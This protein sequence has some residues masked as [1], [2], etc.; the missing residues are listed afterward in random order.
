[1]SLASNP[2]LVAFI[3]RSDSGGKA[4][5]SVSTCIARYDRLTLCC[6]SSVAIGDR[7]AAAKALYASSVTRKA[8]SCIVSYCVMSCHVRLRNGNETLHRIE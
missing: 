8:D 2:A 6:S 7:I 3:N 5:S 4:K 1:M